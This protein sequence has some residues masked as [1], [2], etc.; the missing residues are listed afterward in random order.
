MRL[1]IDFFFVFVNVR[2][3]CNSVTILEKDDWM[4]GFDHAL[5]I[6]RLI[7]IEHP[8]GLCLSFITKL[9]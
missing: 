4:L 5:I 2:F 7:K 9:S 3:N 8:H 6:A 1:A